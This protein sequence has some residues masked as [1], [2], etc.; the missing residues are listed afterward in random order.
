MHRGICMAKAKYKKRADGRYMTRVWNGTYKDNGQ[1]NYEVLYSNKSSKD[2]EEK[3]TD[4]KASIKSGEYVIKKD[5]SFYEYSQIWMKTYKGTKE[6][7][8]Q[9]MYGWIIPKYMSKLEYVMVYDVKRF[10]LQSLINESWEHPRTCRIIYQTFKQIVKAAIYDRMLPATALMDIFYEIDMQKYKVKERRVLTEEE[11]QA[12]QTAKFSDKEKAFVYIIYGCGLRR[13]ETLALTIY[14]IDFKKK[15]ISI[16]KAV[17]FDGNRPNI[18]SPK[19]QNGFRQV[20][21]P[22]F[23]VSFLRG[24]IS[25]LDTEY[26]FTTKSKEMMTETSYR[27]MWSSII[28]KMN[29][30]AGGTKQ[31]QVI[32]GLTAHIFRH[33]YCSSLCYQ[34]PDISI[35]KIAKMLGDTEKVVMNVYSHI[36]EE[37]EQ[38][39]KAIENAINF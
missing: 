12:I 23:L 8:T 11:K 7:N 16:T 33:N 19:S 3:V 32:H 31:I 5:I 39:E 27:R 17:E 18:K 29:L 4:F 25:S 6:L 28:K 24:Y 2:L 9:K 30:A 15:E 26:L 20:P 14:D 35:K 21:M 36:L 22:G 38:T 37:Q 13:G 10:H 1:K 34:V